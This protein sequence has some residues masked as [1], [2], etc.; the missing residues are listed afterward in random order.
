MK[1]FKHTQISFE[2]YAG[3]M[4]SWLLEKWIHHVCRR[5]FVIFFVYF[6]VK[7]NKR[8]IQLDTNVFIDLILA[9][10]EAT[11]QFTDTFNSIS[12]HGT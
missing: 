7:I 3:E 2:W 11:C 10:Q 4:G 5:V 6:K 1:H 9:T 12:Q 8:Y